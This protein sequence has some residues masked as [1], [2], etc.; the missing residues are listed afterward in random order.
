MTL[1]ELIQF[2]P[3]YPYL[4]GA[5]IAFRRVLRELLK[6][7]AMYFENS[8]RSNTY[9]IM[10]QLLTFLIAFDK[11]TLQN[12]GYRNT[13]Y[14]FLKEARDAQLRLEQTHSKQTPTISS[15]SS[16]LFVES[17]VLLLLGEDLNLVIS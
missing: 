10:V 15:N 1:P 17:R 2:R 12:P 3:E 8:W 11:F 7:Q 16:E 5:D 13:T 14:E 6:L 9:D 4:T